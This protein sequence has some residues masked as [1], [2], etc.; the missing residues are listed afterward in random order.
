MNPKVQH[1]HTKDGRYV[2]FLKDGV[3]R[4]KVYASKH[5]FRTIGPTGAW[6][7]DYN[8]LFKEIPEGSVMRVGDFEERK[9]YEATAKR[10]R[11]EGVVL[12]FKEGTKDHYTQ[13]FLPLEAFTVSEA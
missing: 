7:I 3:F 9:L 6:G 12:H 11:E 8:V 13:V 4:K 2:G 5:L 10:W 1:M